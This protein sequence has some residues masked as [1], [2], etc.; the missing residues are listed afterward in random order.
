MFDEKK[1]PARPGSNLLPGIVLNQAES[2]QIRPAFSR[3]RD[4]ED[5]MADKKE[6]R[7]KFS[8]K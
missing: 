6:D 3:M 7:S 5:R 4:T 1:P 2:N 8:D